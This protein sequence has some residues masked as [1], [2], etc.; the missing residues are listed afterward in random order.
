LQRLGGRDGQ[1]FKLMECFIKRFPLGQYSQTV[2]EAALELRER[3]N[4]A[5]DIA[6]IHI[7]TVS[8][9]V[10]L[11]ANDP[12][13]WEPPNRETAD[14]SMPYTAAVA[15]ICGDVQVHHFDAE[16]IND[17]AI[18]SLTRKIK[19][20]ASADADKHMPAAMRCY[21]KL[22][23]KSGETHST[24]IDH[25]RGHYKNPMSNAEIEDKFRALARNVLPDAQTTHLLQRLWSLDEIEDAASVAQMTIRD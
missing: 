5:D 25:F 19:I 7:E 21:F 12:E 22:T 3:I 9:A 14:H 16:Y 8:T 24:M 11:M 1:P 6:E 15:L 20:K 23:T 18:R 13:K 4:S 10:L 2:V 17:P